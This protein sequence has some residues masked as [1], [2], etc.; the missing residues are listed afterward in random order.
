MAGWSG[1][2]HSNHLGLRLERL[3]VL[4]EQLSSFFVQRA[5]WK[6]HDQQTLYSFENVYEAPLCWVPVLLQGRNANIACL[7]DVR[8]KYFSEEVAFGWY[9]RKLPT[10][11]YFA[12]E[13]ASFEWCSN[14]ELSF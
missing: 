4:H 6:R 12:S 11:Y 1:V 8:V 9:L 7:A 13:N 5:L 2:A 10:Q 3:V 14:F